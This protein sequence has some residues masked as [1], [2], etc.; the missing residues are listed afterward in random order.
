MYPLAMSRPGTLLRLL[1]GAHLVWSVLLTPAGFE[2]RPFSSFTPLAYISL[3]LIFTTIGLDIVAFL[4][5]GRRPRLAGLLASIGPF[6]F[7]GPFF[8][9]QLGYFSSLRAPTVIAVL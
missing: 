4:I 9:D 5:V 6:L 8:V 2:T 7:V 3:A 1:I